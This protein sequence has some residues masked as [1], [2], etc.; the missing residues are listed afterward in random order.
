M[1]TLLVGPNSDDEI[2]R[3]KG[4]TIMT[5]QERAEIVR[6][7]KW[8]DIVVP[9]TPY[10]CTT[11]LLDEL[12]CQYFVHGDDPVMCD[13]VNVNEHL[14]SINRFKEV[15]R[16]TGISTT[17]LTGKLLDLL[18]PEYSEKSELNVSDRIVNPPKQ[19]F[20]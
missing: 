1:H 5:G 6:S 13:G 11:Q 10:E 14:K 19:T 12:N 9:D 17:D 18:N 20:L 16:T 15:R 3:Y 2:L 8:G 7:I 4:P